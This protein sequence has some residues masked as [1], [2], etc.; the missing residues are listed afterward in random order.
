L[1]EFACNQEIVAQARRNLKQDVWDYLMGGAESEMTMR[2]NRCA[3]DGYA[4]IPRVLR[5][6]S[7]VDP[8]T[9]VLGHKL[10]IPVLLAPIGSMQAIVQGGSVVPCRAASQFGTIPMVSSIT[11]PALEESA[12]SAEGPKVFQLYVRGDFDWIKSILARVKQAGFISLA[13]TVDSAYYGIRERQL[14]NRYVPPSVKVQKN[15]NLQ[16]AIT[17]DLMS[18]IRDEWGG[19]FILKGV[20]SAEDARIAMEKGVDVIYVSNHG[21]RQ[22]DHSLGSLDCLVDIAAEVGGRAEIIVDGAI[23]RGTDV[24]KALALG[25]NAV[26]IGRLQGWAMA[27]GGESGLVR[28]LELLEQEIINVLGLLGVRTFEDLDLSYIRKAEVI[29]PTHELST[30]YHLPSRLT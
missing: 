14:M 21:G 28:C 25:A 30:F 26:A 22:L 1:S 10:R 24:V 4:F 12:V 19:P 16:S 18:R 11:E 6:M 3:L 27:A 15:R 9:T 17:W 8:S 2:R 5:D 29:G 20:S 23:L 13:L 7:N